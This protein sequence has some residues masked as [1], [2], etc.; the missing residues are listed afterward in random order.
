MIAVT[1]FTVPAEEA[2]SFTGQAR[3]VLTALETMPGHDGGRL[4]R[5]MDDQ[6]LWLMITEWEG[7]GFYRRALSN[8]EVRMAI[9]PLMTY[10][11]NE[12]GA[13]EPV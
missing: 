11:I 8:F 6:D 7:A 1:R 5:A 2:E 12:P 13:Y 4:A 9:L 3:S 10:M